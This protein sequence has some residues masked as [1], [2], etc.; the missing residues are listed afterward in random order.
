MV[1]S[2]AQDVMQRQPASLAV[3]RVGCYQGA[4]EDK[5]VYDSIWLKIVQSGEMG[6]T[7]IFI[8]PVLPPGPG[9][10]VTMRLGQLL[11]P[12]H[13]GPEMAMLIP[14]YQRT[15]RAS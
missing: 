5:E 10:A 11:K 7:I 15:R 4:V 3:N 1:I 12:N 2:K 14:G 8:I 9:W 13:P 6:L